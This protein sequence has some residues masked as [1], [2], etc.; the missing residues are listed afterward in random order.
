VLMPWGTM[1]LPLEAIAKVERTD[2]PL[3]TPAGGGKLFLTVSLRDGTRLTGRCRLE[4]M[5]IGS[6]YGILKIPLAI[7]SAAAIEQR[8]EGDETWHEAVIE[9]RNGDRVR[10]TPTLKDLSLSTP[11]GDVKI[12]LAKVTRLEISTEPAAGDLR[13]GLLLHYDF[14]KAPEK[15][16]PDVSGNDLH[17][18]VQGSTG[19]VKGVV[20]KGI[21]FDGKAYLVVGSNPTGGLK[22]MSVSLWF[23]T[24]R[25]GENYKLAATAKW[26]GPGVGFGW[27]V[28]THYPE[29][30]DP[31]RKNIR[32]SGAERG[33]P[34]KPDEWNHLA[35]VYDGEWL[36]E[37]VNGELSR[38]YP[39]TGQSIGEGGQLTIG[40]WPPFSAYNFVGAMDEFRLYSR[41]LTPGEVR[42]LHSLGT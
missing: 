21:S 1:D 3:A 36:R 8:S 4:V 39:A 37:Y 6:A 12:P 15:T 33:I 28:G 13:E 38:K 16:V 5:R 31:K 10:G 32:R 18:R 35:V 42:S 20:G 19:S 26:Y 7:I 27:I 40:A 25:P 34:F 30:W 9:L 11:Y 29:M 22:R 24:A 41:A 17:A 14:E 23:R 2:R